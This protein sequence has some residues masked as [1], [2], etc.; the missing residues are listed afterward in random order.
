MEKKQIKLFS[1]IMGLGTLLCIVFALTTITLIT[2]KV[3]YDETSLKYYKQ[4]VFNNG[5]V[6]IRNIEFNVKTRNIKERNVLNYTIRFYNNNEELEE[7]VTISHVFN[8]DANSNLIITPSYSKTFMNGISK[9][10]ITNLKI[11]KSTF[12]EYVIIYGSLSFIV[13]LFTCSYVI[14]K[15]KIK[16]EEEPIIEE[17][18][19]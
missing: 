10:E 13:V 12:P 2:P 11:E 16:T 14:V 15:Y 3:I 6:N 8:E 18:N 4:D 19:L 1:I 7:E 9:I 5:P 17:I